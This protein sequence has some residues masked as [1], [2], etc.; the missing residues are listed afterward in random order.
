MAPV[1]CVDDPSYCN[2]YDICVTR[3]VWADLKKAMTVVLEGK[4]LE[5]LI[6]RQKEKAVAEPQAAMYY[7]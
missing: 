7:I 4:T 5:D 2:R 3:E 1:E 6:E